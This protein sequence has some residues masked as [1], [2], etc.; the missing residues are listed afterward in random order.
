MIKCIKPSEAVGMSGTV[1]MVTDNAYEKI[2]SDHEGVARLFRNVIIQLD[3]GTR[4]TVFSI[5]RLNVDDYEDFS[6]FWCL[7]KN[8]RV[9]VNTKGGLDLI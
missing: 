1:I 4:T 9:C 7:V 3:N 6:D 8:D 2:I 5:Y